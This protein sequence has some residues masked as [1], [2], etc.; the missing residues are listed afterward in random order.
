LADR[1]G[2]TKGARE[3]LKIETNMS[4]GYEKKKHV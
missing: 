1:E 2:Y 3:S 4:F